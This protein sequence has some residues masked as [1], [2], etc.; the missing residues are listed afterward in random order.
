M[1][2]WDHTSSS[3]L[4]SFLSGWGINKRKSWG[5]LR[6]VVRQQIVLTYFFLGYEKHI[7]VQNAMVLPLP[8]SA[9]I[10]SPGNTGWRNKRLIWNW[11]TVHDARESFWLCSTRTVNRQPKPHMTKRTK[12]PSH[13]WILCVHP[14]VPRI[15][16]VF[17]SETCFFYATPKSIIRTERPTFFLEN[18]PSL[19]V[20]GSE[21]QALG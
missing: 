14:Q 13:H 4:H 20:I 10:R 12:P 6:E 17:L 15:S 7:R 9:M 5:L 8:W 18:I 16:V 11:V 21:S 2:S 1:L 3:M 19:L